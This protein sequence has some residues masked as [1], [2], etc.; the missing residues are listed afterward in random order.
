MN[1][2]N[3]ALIEV[4]YWIS[5][6]IGGTIFILRMILMFVAGVDG[7]DFEGDFDGHNYRI[8]SLYINRPNQDDIGFLGNTSSGTVENIDESIKL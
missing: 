8:D 2:E 7:G 1:F 4:I 3:M 5:T 6:I